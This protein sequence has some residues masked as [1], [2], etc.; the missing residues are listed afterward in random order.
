M[1]KILSLI[2]GLNYTTRRNILFACTGLMSAVVIGALFLTVKSAIDDGSKNV[3]VTENNE[4][5]TL[6]SLIEKGGSAWKELKNGIG[7]ISESLTKNISTSTESAEVS[8]IADVNTQFVQQLK[9]VT[10]DK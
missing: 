5:G 10:K 8:A 9:E 2:H 3:A 4:P 7:V 1:K 6:D